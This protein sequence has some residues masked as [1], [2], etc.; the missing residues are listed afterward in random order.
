MTF[1]P[2]FLQQEYINTIN[3]L[4]DKGC[5]EKS[6]KY[7]PSIIYLINKMRPVDR[8]PA[9]FFEF[10]FHK[11]ISQ[12]DNIYIRAVDQ[13]Y[14]LTWG[15]DPQYKANCIQI[16]LELLLLDN[17]IGI[18]LDTLNHSL[19]AGVVIDVEF[20]KSI[21]ITEKITNE[22]KNGFI[23][24]AEKNLDTLLVKGITKQTY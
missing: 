3:A 2:T 20:I 9:T 4:F 17:R 12:P 22:V 1:T 18:F 23:K 5:L 13:K 7:L 10:W 21:P 8:A 6:G 16:F 14:D 11:L 19:K 24:T 15:L